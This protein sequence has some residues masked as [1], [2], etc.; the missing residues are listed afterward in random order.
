MTTTTLGIL[1]VLSF[2]IPVPI[3]AWLDRTPRSRREN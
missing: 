1:I 3:L 2:V